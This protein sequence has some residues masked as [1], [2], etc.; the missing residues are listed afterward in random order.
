MPELP[1]VETL[2]RSLVP[3]LIGRRL[4]SVDV[5]SPALREPLDRRALDDLAG[6]RVETLRRRSKY[7][8]VD[9]EAARTLV[10]HLG[11][12]GRFTIVANDHPRDRHEHVVFG[13]DGGERLRY[14]DPRRFG[15]VFALDT[16]GI[17]ADRHF[18]HL[19]IEPFDEGFDGRHLSRAAVGRR[20][21]V[22]TFLMDA[23][24]VVGVGNI[25]ASET[26]WRARVHPRRSVARVSA[27]TWQRL[28]D[29]VR[30][31]LGRAIDEGGTTLSDFRDGDGNSGYFQVSLEVYGRAGEPCRRC[32][33]G[34]RRIVQSNR[35]SYYCP[36]CQR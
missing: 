27:A 28:A 22:K 31:T 11:M 35:A 23:G 6:R 1:E 13:L 26:L 5:L 8:L 16:Q 15:Q 25:Y 2:R 19:G 34:I 20:G 33:R 29:A 32:Q 24:V 4:A 10:V 30:T 17:A 9:L 12:S 7:L 18:V 21:P 14:V 36:G 3:R